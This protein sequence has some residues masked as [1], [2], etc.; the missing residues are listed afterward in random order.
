MELVIF[1]QKEIEHSLSFC[2]LRKNLLEIYGNIHDPYHINFVP[3]YGYIGRSQIHDDM[4]ID[5]NS[6]DKIH[7]LAKVLHQQNL[8]IPI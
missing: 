8:C 7:C 3:Q 1:F 5:R 2:L 4:I 6:L